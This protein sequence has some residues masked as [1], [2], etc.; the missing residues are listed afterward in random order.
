VYV[1]FNRAVDTMSV[2]PGVNLVVEGTQFKGPVFYLNSGQTLFFRGCD[3]P[4]NDLTPVCD[5]NLALN[6]N[7][8]AG[9]AIRSLDGQVLDGDGDG[10]DGG[11]YGGMVTVVACGL[12]P[13][14]MEFPPHGFVM[15]L[16]QLGISLDSKDP[17]TVNFL[18]EMDTLSFVPGKSVYLQCE[19]DPSRIVNGALSWITPSAFQFHPDIT[20]AAMFANCDLYRLVVKST[21]PYGVRGTNGVPLNGD[22]D[23]PGLEDFYFFIQP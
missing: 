5:F 12:A 1:F 4:C 9:T 8:N 14:G 2:V 10:A 17:L 22:Q 15:P 19:T 21:G 20:Y 16:G 13:P 18:G 23:Q 3:I 11:A 7:G 6:P